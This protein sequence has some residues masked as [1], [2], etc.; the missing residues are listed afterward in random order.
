MSRLVQQPGERLVVGLGLLPAC[1]CL[2][3]RR[4]WRK[5][6]ISGSCLGLGG[7]GAAGDEPRL[8]IE[9]VARRGRIR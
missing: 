1:A 8:L 2:V 3:G 5:G 6:L 9:S 4:C 7:F